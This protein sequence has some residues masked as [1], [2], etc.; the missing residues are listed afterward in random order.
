[1]MTNEQTVKTLNDLLTKAYDAEQGYAQAAEKTA[2]SPRL[3]NFFRLES[4]L[5][6]SIGRDLKMLISHY[7]G[8]PDKGASVAAKAHQIWIAM[9]DFMSSNDEEA[10]LEECERG[11]SAALEE[12][13]EALSNPDL[14]IDVADILR[15]HRSKIADALS[16]IRVNEAIAGAAD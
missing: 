13:D 2:D 15:E 12:Y 8:E 4:A 16:T 3:A 9:K 7:G 1:M 11:E 5:R 14:P 6:L 10:V